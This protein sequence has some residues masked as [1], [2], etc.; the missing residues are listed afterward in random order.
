MGLRPESAG[1]FPGPDRM[2]P[3]PVNP[4]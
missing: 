2:T 4:T 3:I 1:G